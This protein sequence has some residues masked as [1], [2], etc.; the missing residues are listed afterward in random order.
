MDQFLEEYMK[1]LRLFFVLTALNLWS[2]NLSY[3]Y[4]EQKLSIE[5]STTNQKSCY[6]Q[7]LKQAKRRDILVE[8]GI[9]TVLVGGSVAT[10]GTTGGFVL[11]GATAAYGTAIA[12]TRATD[13]NFNTFEKVII[14]YDESL[15]AE[16]FSNQYFLKEFGFFGEAVNLVSIEEFGTELTYKKIAQTLIQEMKNNGLCPSNKAMK[17]KRAVKHIAEMANQK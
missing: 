2:L 6:E 1:N 17:F 13:Y 15:Q 9:Y 10:F 7:Y 3:G 4:E 14:P 5:N 8:T 16:S 11:L 12:S